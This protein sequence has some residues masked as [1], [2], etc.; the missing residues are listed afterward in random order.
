MPLKLAGS[1][2]LKDTVK[3]LCPHLL[4]VFLWVRFDV[5]TSFR[6]QGTWKLPAS[7]SPPPNLQNLKERDYPPTGST[8]KS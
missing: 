1:E 3:S 5:Q 2:S 8:E 6:W 4:A 7:D